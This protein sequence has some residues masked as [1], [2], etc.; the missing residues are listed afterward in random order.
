MGFENLY[1]FENVGCV[2]WVEGTECGLTR[3]WQGLGR[4]KHLPIQHSTHVF[5]T[6]ALDCGG[7][8]TVARR[9]KPGQFLF[10]LVTLWCQVSVRMCSAVLRV[11]L[12]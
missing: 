1:M 8:H 4:T 10:T 9:N 7:A 5:T 2:F 6:A 12:K 3:G 11:V